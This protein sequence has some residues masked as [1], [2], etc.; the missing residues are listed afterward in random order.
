MVLQSARRLA[1]QIAGRAAPSG[2]GPKVRAIIDAHKGVVL[3]ATTPAEAGDSVFTT[4]E[5]E[6]M[7]RASKLAA[8]LRNIAGIEAVY[9]KPAE[10]PP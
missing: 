9:A 10:E 6:D 2:T 7:D 4:I 1:D 5:V 3:P 8:A